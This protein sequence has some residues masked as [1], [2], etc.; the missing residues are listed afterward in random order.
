MNEDQQIDHCNKDCKKCPLNEIRP[1]QVVNGIGPLNARVM[2][3]GE[4]PGPDED[5]T[6]IPFVGKAGR[7]L[8]SLLA[9]ISVHRSQVRLTNVARCF[10]A[11]KTAEGFRPPSWDETNTCLPYLEQEIALI[12]PTVII[13]LGNPAL[14]ALLGNKKA[15]I[16]NYRGTEVWSEKYNCKIMPTMHPSAVLR[17]PDLE[18]TVMQD[19]K[20]AFESSA[21]PEMTKIPEGNYITID[22]IEKFD[23]FYK[24]IME[25]PEYAFDLETSG[26]NWQKDEILCVSFSWKEGTAVVLPIRKYVPVEHE[27]IV[28]KEKKVKRKG[29]V[30]V[31]MIEEIEKW[32]ED[33]YTPYWGDQQQYVMMN[34]MAIICSNIPRIA[35]NGKFDDKFFLQMGWNIQPLAYD[36][37]L[38]H[39]LLNESGKGTHNLE[40]MSLQYT[41]LG[42]YKRESEDWFENQ[43][44]PLKKRN[45]AQLPLDILYRRNAKDADAT[46]RLKN[47]FLA[48]LAEEEMVD[49]LN[50]LIMPLNH[51]LMVTEFEGFKIDRVAS[52][53]AKNELQAEMDAKIAEIKALV[54]DVDLDSPKQLSKLLFEDLKLPPVKTT[55]TGFSTD[56]EVLMVL[57]DKHPVPEKIVQYRGIAK[58]LRTYVLGI[59]EK[60]DPNDRLHTKFLIEG[61]ESG[62]LS[63]QNPNFQNFPKDDKRIKNQFIV[64]PGN[65]LIEADEGQNEFRWWG[66]LSNDPQLVADLNAGL[67]IHKFMA[68]LAN[69]IPMEQVDKKQRQIAKSIVFGL[70]FNMGAEKLAKDHN[71][72]VAYAEE[73][74][75]IFFNRY[76][77][78]KQWKL[79][80]VKFARRN[81]YVQNRFGRIRHLIAINN[82]DKKIAYA[83]EQAAVNSP[84]QGAASDYV[85]NAANR[86]VMRLKEEGLHGRLRNLV[87]DAIYLEAPRE[88]L[89]KSLKIMNEEMTRRILGIQVPLIAEFK[90]G[91]R[92]GRMHLLKPKLVDNLIQKVA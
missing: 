26:L 88:E 49:L 73:V 70:M 69:K 90:M 65:V 28:Q 37:L 85:S 53:K 10:P 31:T 6:G 34:L 23:A 18:E 5:R 38:M 72:T 76:P 82:D 83:D 15:T 27:R 47:T 61:T 79:D 57:K 8:D 92:W 9:R 56:E 46:L 35:Q 60:L 80:I 43:N 16:S 20:R 44:I 7:K 86:I 33:T 24:R 30:S 74:K 19:L 13:A 78:A 36:T 64:A 54:G 11:L 81:Y 2:I 50:R 32:V 77:I 75:A 22:N 52:D 68:S 63:S 40:D 59:Q 84:I 25:V 42:N 87:H 39:Y 55:K 21:Y 67:D 62:R 1:T 29:V 91:T 66:I 4:A 14:K 12:K 45:F 41:T 51:N 48:M 58:N 89:E 3:V 71:V 17:N